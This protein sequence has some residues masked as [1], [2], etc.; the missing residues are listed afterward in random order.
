MSKFTDFIDSVKDSAGILAKKELKALI[1]DGKKDTSDFVRRQAED[2]ERFTGMLADG[3]LT[4]E[5]FKKL[6]RN[7]AVLTEL[8]T[9]KL[10]VKAMA[11]AQRLADGIREMVINQL[12]KLI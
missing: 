8:E 6:V 7:M 5:G 10:K 4:P 2:L 12:F 9:I 11:A 3:D 1:L